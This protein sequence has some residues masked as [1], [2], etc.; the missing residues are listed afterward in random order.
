MWEAL[1]HLYPKGNWIVE[2][3]E[4]PLSKIQK[5][6]WNEKRNENKIKYSLW[7]Q[8]GRETR[9]VYG[10]KKSLILFQRSIYDGMFTPKI[11]I[12]SFTYIIWYNLGSSMPNQIIYFEWIILIYI[13]KLS[14]N[15]WIY[16][17]LF[18]MTWVA[19]LECNRLKR[20]CFVLKKRKIFCICWFISTF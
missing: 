20:K 17:R 18:Q 11:C 2:M 15:A 8:K 16:E 14:I 19:S 9:F 5:I 1:L 12:P 4:L 10:W 3:L 6:K 13:H 7:I